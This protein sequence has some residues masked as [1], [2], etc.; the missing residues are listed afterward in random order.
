MS[1]VGHIQT[2]LSISPDSE[3]FLEVFRACMS[4]A[5][6]GYHR[7]KT[8]FHGDI[9]ALVDFKNLS[10]SPKDFR[11]SLDQQRYCTVNIKFYVLRVL[12]CPRMTTEEVKTLY[13]K[14]ELDRDDAAAIW[15][16]F[17]DKKYA[18]IMRSKLLK[19]FDFKLHQRDV[20]PEALRT[21][22]PLLAQLLE[23]MTRTIKG[24]VR[25]KLMWIATSQNITY[26]DL[27]ADLVGAVVSA[28]N[29]SVP[30]R[31]TYQHHVNYLGVSCSN[32]VRNI[33]AE[34]SSDKRRRMSN[35]G[36]KDAPK[37]EISVMSENQMTNN[38]DNEVSYESLL[39]VEAQTHTSHME[40]ELSAD[41][42]LMKTHGTKRGLLYSILLGRDVPEFTGFLQDTRRLR[43]DL[44]TGLDWI[45]GKHMSE[46]VPVVSEWLAVSHRAVEVGVRKLGW[47]LGV[48]S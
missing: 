18:S 32:R 34:Y 25:K 44:K 2:N 23:D 16:L 35:V 6:R 4:Y 30:N 33:Q 40:F 29:Q 17:R 12:L 48:E 13:R 9:A 1:L 42:I 36:T 21:L 24:T 45:S 11:M 46:I 19:T 38:P 20:S 28:F 8:D 41:E 3:K 43:G 47:S 27:E 22:K 7:S 15:N 5:S 37:Y 39:G 31:F 14:Y 26:S 10:I